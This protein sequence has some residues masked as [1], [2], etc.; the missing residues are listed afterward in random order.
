MMKK[1]VILFV[2][3]MLVMGSIFPVFAAN[4]NVAGV[5][6][7]VV[8]VIATGS[9]GIIAFGSGFYLGNNSDYEYYATNDHV[10]SDDDITGFGIVFYDL[11]SP[12]D[13]IEA[14]AVYQTYGTGTDLAIIKIPRERDGDGNFKPSRRK[15]VTLGSSES[16]TVT[17]N[18]YA[19]GF[20]AV[21]D[22]LTNNYE[23]KSK[24]EDVIVTSGTV[25][26]LDKK[27]SNTRSMIIDANINNGN[28]GGPLVD[29]KGYVV[30]INTWGLDGTN[31]AIRVEELLDILEGRDVPYNTSGSNGKSAKVDNFSNDAPKQT[32]DSSPVNSDSDFSIKVDSKTIGLIVAVILAF[33][34]ITVMIVIIVATQKTKNRKGRKKNDSWKTNNTKNR[35]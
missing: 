31:A 7:S 34:I 17:S 21:A 32:K 27:I 8:R 25:S 24:P 23:F 28:S 22:Q 12:D 33:V 5:S 2:A 11:Y 35:L 30:G 20:P 16:L 9:D 14:T 13:I 15:P 3:V 6:D 10:I 4:G 1:T 19:L 18:I 29:E 26:N